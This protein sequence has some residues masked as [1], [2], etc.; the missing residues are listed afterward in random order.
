MTSEFKKVTSRHIPKFKYAKDIF[1]AFITLRIFA[2]IIEFFVYYTV[3]H[4]VGKSKAEIGKGSKIHTTVILRQAKNIV[5]G[6]GCLINH[7]TVLQAGKENAKIIIGDYV[8]TGTNVMIIAFNHAFDT[9]NIPIIKQD[10]YDATVK[11]EDDVW[12][13]GGAVILAGVTVGKGSII[14]AGAVVNKDVPPYAIVGGVPA[15]VLKFRNDG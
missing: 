3:N 1:W 9:R 10:Y 2:Y 14:A 11:I 4:V 7:N 12:I 5:I 6:K 8:H 13:G 15:R